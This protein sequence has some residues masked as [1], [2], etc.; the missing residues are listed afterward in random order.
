MSD[1]DTNGHTPK[2]SPGSPLRGLSKFAA[3]V[4]CVALV[5]V[6]VLLGIVV[7]GSAGF[8][9]N[10]KQ[11]VDG[12]V[13]RP[14][15]LEEAIA[16]SAAVVQGMIVGVGDSSSTLRVDEVLYA[17]P[18]FDQTTQVEIVPTQGD[19]E[20]ESGIWVLG[21]GSPAEVLVGPADADVYSVRRVL[22][23]EAASLRPPTPEEIRS[24]FDQA[25]LVV[26]GRV[27]ASDS[28]VGSIAVEE[29]L[30]GEASGDFEIAKND[31]DQE[32]DFPTAAPS[33]GTYFLRL[34]GDGWKVLNVQAPAAYGFSAVKSATE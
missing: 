15:S 3:V 9:S 2:R 18:S 19:V 10:D 11:E 17:D 30:K 16:D 25:D 1:S 29:V 4:L 14:P 12:G 23:G 34:S 24:L 21:P 26:F 20:G 32:W 7:R 28:S 31:V 5:P 33:Y 27:T 6:F 22:A 8:S 13:T